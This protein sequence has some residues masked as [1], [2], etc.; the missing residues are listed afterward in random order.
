M[1]HSKPL[2]GA[3]REERAVRLMRDTAANVEHQIRVVLDQVNDVQNVN[4]ARLPLR[5]ALD[6]L[7]AHK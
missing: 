6:A 4:H 7:V 3:E 1:E 2:S 5:R